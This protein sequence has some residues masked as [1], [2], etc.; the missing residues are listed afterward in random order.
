MT[1]SE[2]QNEALSRAVSGQSTRNYMLIITTLEK[3]GIAP[4]DIKLRENIFTYNAW[5]AL[6]RQ[7][8]KGEHGVKITTFI[9][10]KKKPKT[11]DPNEKPEYFN[12][13]WTTSVFHITQTDKLAS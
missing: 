2:K 5:K 11:A 9:Q 12:K 8:R 10:G 4:E 3:K 1:N 13:P 7:V 6:G